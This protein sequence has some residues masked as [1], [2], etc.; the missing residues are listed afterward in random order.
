M[1]EIRTPLLYAGL[2]GDV[3]L[4]EALT[5]IIEDC[6]APGIDPREHSNRVEVVCDGVCKRYNI[7]LGS[8]IRINL[9]ERADRLWAANAA[10]HESKS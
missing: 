7:P 6:W 8:P 10:A 2:R 1:A 4:D 9:R 3:D 5:A